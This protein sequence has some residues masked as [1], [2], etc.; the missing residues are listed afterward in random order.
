MDKEIEKYTYVSVHY[1]DDEIPH[2]T[3]YYIS[4]IEDLKEGNNVL[5]DR[6]GYETIG[7]VEKLEVFTKDKVPFPI[8]KVKH[9][10]REVPDCEIDKW[11]DDYEEYE[12][13]IEDYHKLFLNTMFSRLSI[14]R[15][16]KLMFVEN[17]AIELT[18]KLFYMPRMNLFFYKNK[19]NY[20]IAETD[21]DILSDE[22]FRILER[23][24]IEVPRKLTYNI[25]TANNYE[26]AILFCRKNDI[27]IYDDTD[28]TD[29]TEIK[30]K[31][32]L[33]KTTKKKEVNFKRIEDIIE[34]LKNY[35]G[36]TYKLPIPDYCIKD[37]KIV[38][39]VG[40]IDYDSRIFKLYE[41]LINNR[42]VDINKANKDYER[43]GNKWENW[44][45]WN[46][47]KLSYSKLNYIII[48][49]YNAERI[50]SGLINYYAQ[51][52]KLL[53]VVEKIAEKFD[54]NK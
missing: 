42:Y 50:Y 4:D 5:V 52:G 21:T 16:L 2:R 28:I 38:H 15:L 54:C 6:N 36:A 51:S 26:E 11:Y 37:N 49:L 40:W 18:D 39:F 20:K 47:E 3:Y 23:E 9:I 46:I 1:K 10:I 17:S 41:F 14:K 13:E 27:V 7:V 32:N 43:Y 25:Y 24:S 33:Y 22:I 45:R 35:K 53:K 31:L 44:E 48:R 34:Y 29:F 30:S 8:E 19:D 12:A